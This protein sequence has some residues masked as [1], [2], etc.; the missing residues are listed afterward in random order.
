MPA[1]VGIADTVY[2]G[3]WFCL[4]TAHVN[5]LVVFCS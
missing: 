4:K 1:A 5:V 2:S 3:D